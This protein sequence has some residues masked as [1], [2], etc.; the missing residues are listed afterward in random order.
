MLRA[1][2]EGRWQLTTVDAVA[3]S[4]GASAA[5]AATDGVISVP[6]QSYEVSEDVL[7]RLVMILRR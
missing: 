5:V 3:A 6:P 4:A 2:E 1:D 7:K